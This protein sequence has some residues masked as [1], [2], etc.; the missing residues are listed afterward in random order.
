MEIISEEDDK[1]FMALFGTAWVVLV[2]GTSFLTGFSASSIVFIAVGCA[3]FPFML[4]KKHVVYMDKTGILIKKRGQYVCIPFEMI[5][6]VEKSTLEPG[7]RRLNFKN[8]TVFGN[9]ILFLPRKAGI[10]SRHQA[11]KDFLARV[12]T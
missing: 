5:R 2:L 10:F 6:S 4:I 1:K 9:Y 3:Y 7:G 8:E 11:Y 12:A